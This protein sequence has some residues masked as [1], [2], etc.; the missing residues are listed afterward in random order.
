MNAFLLGDFSTPEAQELRP[1]RVDHDQETE[2]HEDKRPDNLHHE[3][4]FAFDQFTPP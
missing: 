2:R 1:D 3:R 4:N